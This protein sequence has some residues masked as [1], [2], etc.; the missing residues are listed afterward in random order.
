MPS[1]LTIRRATR[2]DAQQIVPLLVAQLRGLG[3]STP[4]REIAAAVDGM[5]GNGSRGFI[6]LAMIGGRPIGVA[7][8]S[9]VWTL[10]HGGLSAWLEELYVLPE[11]RGRGIG[12]KLLLAAIDGAWSQGCHAMD[13]EVDRRHPR[14]SSL[15]NREGFVRLLRSRWVLKS[16]RRQV[17]GRQ[18]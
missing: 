8:V 16:K 4:E 14:A 15:Y 7:Y 3:E 9:F 6:L 17:G 13:L 5:I 1:K 2:R 11:H 10:E 18:G 12:R